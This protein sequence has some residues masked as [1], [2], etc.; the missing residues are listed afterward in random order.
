M[1]TTTEIQLLVTAKDQASNTLKKVGSS[2]EGVARVGKTI[3]TG[4][5]V[6][7]VAAVAFGV[8]AVKAYKIGRAHV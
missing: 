8:K 1:A 7:G 5:A 4:L 6:G 2:M 3:A